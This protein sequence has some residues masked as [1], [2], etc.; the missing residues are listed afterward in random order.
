MDTETVI[1][2]K[3]DNHGNSKNLRLSAQNSQKVDE[4]VE[5][6]FKHGNKHVRT[7]D[8]IATLKKVIQFTANQKVEGLTI[9]KAHKAVKLYNSYH[10]IDMNPEE[11]I[12]GWKLADKIKD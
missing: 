3:W 8:D 1:F 10:R 7:V 4:E 6:V 12:K 2:G 5:L 9:E 11:A